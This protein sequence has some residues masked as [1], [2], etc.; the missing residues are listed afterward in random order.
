MTKPQAGNEAN[1]TH[2]QDLSRDAAAL[3]LVLT[4]DKRE[5]CV[6]TS[7]FWVRGVRVSWLSIRCELASGLVL[8][9]LRLQAAAGRCHRGRC[10]ESGFSH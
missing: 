2:L 9:M 3:L 10:A 6:F 1:K 8:L 5:S 4:D 7:F